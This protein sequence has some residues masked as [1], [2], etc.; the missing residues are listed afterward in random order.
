MKKSI[1]V[2]LSALS[3]WGC[4]SEEAPKVAEAPK[5]PEVQQQPAQPAPVADVKPTCGVAAPVF[6]CTV[7]K[8]P[9][10]LC[11]QDVSD[12]Q[13]VVLTANVDGKEIVAAA[14]DASKSS[15]IKV[16]SV[17]V[18]PTTYNSIYFEDQ[19]S[20]YALTRCPEC[21]QSPWLTI[22]KGNQKVLT[23]QC[24]DDSV[25]EDRID[26]QFKRDKKGRVIKDGLYQEKKSKLNFTS[27]VN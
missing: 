27:P 1:L 9:L 13:E 18:Q 5:Q 23:A 22:Y 26:M 15:P 3:L 4:G 8:R 20:T 11:T 24:D 6:M 2:C 10:T 14:D 25:S 16:E 17:Y 19:G 21:M 7:N 12:T